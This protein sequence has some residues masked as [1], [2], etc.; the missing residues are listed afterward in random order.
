MNSSLCNYQ[1]ECF[2]EG[3]IYVLESSRKHLWNTEDLRI[4]TRVFRESKIM[5]RLFN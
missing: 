4:V 3:M 1:E 5:K 2:V